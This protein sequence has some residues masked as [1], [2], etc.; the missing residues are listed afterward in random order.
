M[1]TLFTF[2]SVIFFFANTSRATI[3]GFITK[4]GSGQGLYTVPAGKILVL[5]Q[6]SYSLSET[7]VNHYLNI[8]NTAVYFP[9]ATNGLYT[10]PKAL[11]LPAGTTVT[12]PNT[13][14][15]LIF[16]E[17]I[18]PSDAP[19]F[20]GVGSNLENVSVAGNTVTG[21][22]KLSSTAPSMVLLLG[23]TNLTDWN[24][25]TTVVLQP[26]ADKTRVRFT[27]RVTGPIRF[28]RALVRRA[29]AG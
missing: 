6:V 3:D 13:I 5:Q 1:K 28:Y 17:I 9:A 22:V 20:V 8:N 26:G 14:A 24:Y 23:S 19:L 10:L 7:A 11:F 16:G 4:V 25:D 2:F 15:F 12:S 27:S 29:A 18:D 21:E